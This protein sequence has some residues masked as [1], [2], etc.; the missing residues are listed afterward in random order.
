MFTP[1]AMNSSP[2][3]LAALQAQDDNYRPPAADAMLTGREW[4]EQ[5]L[6]PLSQTDLLADSIRPQTEVL[7]IGRSR[8]LKSDLPGDSRRGDDTFRVECLNYQKLGEETAT[9]IESGLEVL[10]A[11]IVIDCSGTFGNHNEYLPG[12]L[13]STIG[14]GSP[15]VSHTIPDFLGEDREQYTGQHTLLLG[16]GYSAATNLVNLARLADEAPETKVTWLTRSGAGQGGP[17]VRIDQDRLPQRDQ[18]AEQTNQLALAADSPVEWVAAAQVTSVAETEEGKLSVRYRQLLASEPE[19]DDT[20]D[21]E[22]AYQEHELTVDRLVANVGYHPNTDL[23]RELQVH[24][25]YATEGPMKLAAKLLSQAG[26]SADCLD[27][28][29]CGAESLVT[30]EPNFY[31]LGAKSYGRNSNF[32][33]ATGLGQ[34][35]EIFT[36]IGGRESLNLYESVKGLV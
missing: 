12:G 35:R 21:E 1:F 34:I 7:G 15:Q 32:L 26:S 22:P 28:Q 24:L 5:Y 30:T 25:C 14:I 4:V 29:S 27:Q 11:K 13:Q 18:L 36:V 23:F 3:G 17:I 33:V 8:Y 31:V 16:G 9:G 2:L 6:L 10:E 20:D 19:T